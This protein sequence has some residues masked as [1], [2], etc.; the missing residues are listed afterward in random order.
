MSDNNNS[1]YPPEA[2]LNTRRVW[3][4]GGFERKITARDPYDLSWDVLTLECGHESKSLPGSGSSSFS[5]PRQKTSLDC[6]KCRDD[7]FEKECGR[8]ELET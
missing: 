3:E 2:I 6:E 1:K 8:L 5:G 7:F 4:A